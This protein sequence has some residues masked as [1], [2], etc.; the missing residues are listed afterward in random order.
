MLG[1]QEI[2][3]Q[4]TPVESVNGA[5]EILWKTDALVLLLLSSL[6][7]LLNIPMKLLKTL[8]RVCSFMSTVAMVC[9]FRAFFFDI[10][11]GPFRQKYQF[12]KV[13]LILF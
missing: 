11:L 6:K 1:I 9:Y 7:L 2:D 3:A 4:C 13:K 10:N 5:W 12:D 8:L